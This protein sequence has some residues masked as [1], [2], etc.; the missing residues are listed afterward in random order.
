[1]L[2]RLTRL[3][4]YKNPPYGVGTYSN[5][6]GIIE[7]RQ[8]LK[9][10]CIEEIAYRRK[11]I[12]DEQMLKLINDLK[13]GNYKTYFEEQK[14]LSDKIGEKYSEKRFIK[15]LTNGEGFAIIILAVG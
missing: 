10:A 9:I 11:F 5:F 14:K 6:I 1:M 3:C 4:P 13:S 7:K 8:D 15:V 12:S 2:T